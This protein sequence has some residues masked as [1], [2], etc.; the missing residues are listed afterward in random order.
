M[1]GDSCTIS[2]TTLGFEYAE[3][4]RDTNMLATSVITDICAESQT[5]APYAAFAQVGAV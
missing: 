4:T 2:G 5:W 1:R 3:M